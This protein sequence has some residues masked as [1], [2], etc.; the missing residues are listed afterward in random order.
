MDLNKVL[1]G[2]LSKAYKMENGRIAEI[3]E[4]T[5]ESSI[6]ADLLDA[7]RQ[8]VT[9]LSK[10]SA[11]GKEKFKEGY[12]K[13]KKE[14]R[15]AFEKELKDE[16]GI[17]ETSDAAKLQGKELIEH[18]VSEKATEAA[19]GAGK[20]NM[21]DE[22]IRVTPAYRNMEK[23]L[24]KQL[25]VK[26][27]EHAKAIGDLK[28][29][30]DAKETSGSFLSVA[31]DLLSNMK[32]I[33]P[34][35]AKKAA[36]Q[37]DLFSKLLLESVQIVKEADGFVIMKDGKRLDDG[38]GNAIDVQQYVK[39]KADAFFDFE[40]NNGGSNSGNNNNGNDRKP[41]GGDNGG[42]NGKKEYPD[43]FRPKDFSE[44]SK[45]SRDKVISLETRQAIT[46][47]WNEEHGR[48]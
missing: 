5:D 43:G 45:M 21:T 39:D 10:N 34:K 26:E 23:E 33:L 13:A 40:A 44:F 42:G 20:A 7:D 27:T 16:Y 36:T 25:Q 18:I 6:I 28:G 8:R 29:E 15:A 3:L 4:Q 22:E 24:R 41:A 46:E 38:H 11:D 2:L 14:E 32:P 17:D 47:A 19:T 30:Y 35:D 1:T 12:A 9:E 37:R 31:Q 48:D